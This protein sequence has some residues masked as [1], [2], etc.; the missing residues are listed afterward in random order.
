MSFWTENIVGQAVQFWSSYFLSSAFPCPDV[1]PTVSTFSLFSQFPSYRLVAGG[2]PNKTPGRTVQKIIVKVY[3]SNLHNNHYTIL[4]LHLSWL[5]TFSSWQLN[6]QGRRSST[7]NSKKGV[8][9][10]F[11]CTYRVHNKLPLQIVQLSAYGTM[12]SKT[13]HLFIFYFN[14]LGPLLYIY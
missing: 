7:Y 6:V 2:S 8:Q 12:N 3:L 9:L 13:L 11:E 14:L 4:N 10:L 1:S 5:L